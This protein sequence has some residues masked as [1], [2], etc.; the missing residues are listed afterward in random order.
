MRLNLSEQATTTT[1]RRG[2]F[3]LL[4]MRP[5]CQINA[6][7]KDLNLSKGLIGVLSS[8]SANT[9]SASG[10]RCS[11]RPAGYAMAALHAP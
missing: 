10:W 9:A 7:D 8:F 1:T 2:Q 6:Q 11:A 3:D 5:L 4:L